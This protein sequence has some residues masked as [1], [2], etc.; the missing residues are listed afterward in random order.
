[1][2]IKSSN[3]NANNFQG[4]L[5][6]WFDQTEGAYSILWYVSSCVS[7]KSDVLRVM[8]SGRFL[9]LTDELAWHTNPIY[10]RCEHR[11]REHTV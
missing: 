2:T 3:G 5:F 11:I 10:R 1:M 8:M 6:L 4:P 7:N 9:L